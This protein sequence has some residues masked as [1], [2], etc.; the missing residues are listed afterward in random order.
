MNR[1]AG[2]PNVIKGV[3]LMQCCRCSD[4]YHHTCLNISKEKFIT[5]TR[6]IKDSWICPSCRSKEPKSGDNSNT[7]VRTHTA[8]TT[9][10]PQYD[11]VT[12]RVKPRNTSN[13]GCVSAETIRDIIREELDKK[14]CSQIN[15]IQVKLDIAEINSSNRDLKVR[16]NQVEQISRSNNIELQCVPEN[17][18][19]NLYSIVQQLSKTIKCPLSDSDVH[20]CTRIAKQNNNSPRPRA[21]LVKFSNR[22]LRDT[23]LA[24]AIKFNKNNPSNRLN[25]SHLGYGGDKKSVF[26]SEHLTLDA[27]QLHLKTRQRARELNYRYCWTRDGKILVRKSDTSNFIHIK[28]S[29]DLEKL[30]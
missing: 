16:L 10:S 6:D 15:D 4:K 7:P 3:S 14:F 19:E 22:R 5:F 27:K 25:T 21:I 11:N 17:K 1:C 13:C 8:N 2:C 29:L 18:N 12:L 20:Y 28:D 9:V 23:F 26:V 30:T 24:N